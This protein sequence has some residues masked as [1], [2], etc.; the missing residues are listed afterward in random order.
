M[1]ATRKQLELLKKLGIKARKVVNLDSSWFPGQQV[2]PANQLVFF[3]IFTLRALE[4][5]G[6]LEYKTGNFYHKIYGNITEIVI[7]EGVSC[8]LPDKVAG[9]KSG[10]RGFKFHRDLTKI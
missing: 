1:R 9:S 2:I 4:K 10:E 5:K 7:L 3:G 6:F 8:S